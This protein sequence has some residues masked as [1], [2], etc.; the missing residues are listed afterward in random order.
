MDWLCQF[1]VK[2]LVANLPI[3]AA[4]I[5]YREADSGPNRTIA[6]YLQEPDTLEPTMPPGLETGNW[7]ADRWPFLKVSVVGK[8]ADSMYV[9]WLSQDMAHPAYLL[10]WA[11]EPLSAFHKQWVEQI[12]T[13]IEH[14]LRLQQHCARQQAKNQILEQL[15]Q[16]AEHQLRNPLALIGLYA[17]NLRM[18][19]PSGLLQDQAHLIRATV[20]E[21]STHLTDLINSS[22]RSPLRL[23]P[24]DLRLVVIEV[25][26]RLQPWLD[27]K[28]LQVLYPSTSLL[29]LAD[30]WQMQQVFDNLLTNAIHFT[31]DAGTITWSWKIFQDEVLIEVADQGPGLS[32]EDLKQ[33]FIPFYSRRSG[34]TGLGLAIAKK[35]IL[36]HQ[37]SV[38][39]QNLP[40][41]GAQFSFTLPRHRMYVAPLF[42]H[43]P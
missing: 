2:Q 1:Q 40:S 35:I 37:G 8:D 7:S 9:C 18:H 14:Y 29:L 34:G 41:G 31:P 33:A 11:A 16:R 6:Y 10:L 19:L 43:Q 36:D 28:H 32:E 27:Q 25:I 38:W 42:P 22:G 26:Q 39:A 17:E 24:C 5:L 13:A 4:W 23:A 21:L 30:R 3:R 12:A 20:D 15:L